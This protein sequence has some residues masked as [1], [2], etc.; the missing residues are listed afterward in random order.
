MSGR[1]RVLIVDDHPGMLRAV[2]RLLA[3]D[4]DVVG[5]LADARGLLAAAQQLQPDV[6]VLDMNLPDVDGLTVC[7]QITQAY[8]QIKVIVFTAMADPHIRRR[9]FEAG[10]SAFVHKLAADNDLLTAVRWLADDRH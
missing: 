1:L 9:A 10:A 4:Y 3:L 8:P 7:R 5:R 6:V 2:A